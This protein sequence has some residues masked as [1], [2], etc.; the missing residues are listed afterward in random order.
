MASERSLD[1]GVE[2]RSWGFGELDDSPIAAP[3]LA[4]PRRPARALGGHVRVPEL[5][6]VALAGFGWIVVRR[7]VRR[8]AV[9]DLSG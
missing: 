5:G 9:K 1:A 3:S 8:A 6:W 7:R 4:P 2:H